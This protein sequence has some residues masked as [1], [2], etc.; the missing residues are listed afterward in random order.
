LKGSVSYDNC[1]DDGTD[2]FLLALLLFSLISPQNS[3]YRKCDVPS[4]TQNDDLLGLTEDRPPADPLFS[5]YCAV[6]PPSTMMSWPVVNAA[7]GE[8]SQSTA[9]ALCRNRFLHVGLAF[10]EGCNPSEV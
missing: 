1:R 6:Y 5:G 3:F 10:A 4:H 7:S 8:L 9:L 2:L